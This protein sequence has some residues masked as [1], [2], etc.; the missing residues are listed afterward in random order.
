MENI[1]VNKDVCS[2]CGG[3]CCRSMGCHI[4][5][6]NLKEVTYDYIKK[7]LDTGFVSIDYWDGDPI[8]DKNNGERA[9]FL[10]MRNV[11]APVADPS[12]GGQCILLTSKGCP[13][14]FKDRPLGARLLVPKENEE[15]IPEYTKQD[16]AKDWF[17]YNDILDRLWKEYDG[18][19]SDAGN[20]DNALDA[21]VDAIK[22]AR[23]HFIGE[24]K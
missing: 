1:Y 12:W 10:R 20:I 13:L 16:C 9:Y 19:N 24:E 6:S 23:E 14:Q 7:M 17:K 4:S 2:K 21:L 8:T 22:K 15:C 5:P 18:N 3:I 11:N